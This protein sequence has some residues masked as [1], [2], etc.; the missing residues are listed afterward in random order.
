VADGSAVDRGAPCRPRRSRRGRARFEP[1]DDGRRAAATQTAFC[2]PDVL[3]AQGG[4][5][6]L[7]QRAFAGKRRYSLARAAEIAGQVVQLEP[8]F[9]LVRLEADLR[10]ER[11]KRISGPPSSLYWVGA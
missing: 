5:L 4:R 9:C 11:T 10:P 7:D 2:R 1:V 8:G 3:G 6:R